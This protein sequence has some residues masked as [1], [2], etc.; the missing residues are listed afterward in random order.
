[1]ATQADRKT[2]GRT[3]MVVVQKEQVTLS[4]DKR[5]LIG[6]ASDMGLRPGEWP[7]FISVVD[8]NGSGFLFQRGA[9]IGDEVGF[10][11]ATRTGSNFEL[12]VLND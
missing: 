4:E 6:C 3:E 8:A 12:H 11:Y 9:M 10:V 1:M 2:E 7:D 5:Y